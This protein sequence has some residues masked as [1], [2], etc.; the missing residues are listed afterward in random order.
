MDFVVCFGCGG[1]FL[2]FFFRFCFFVERTRPAASMRPPCL[3]YR[4]T[5]TGL[6]TGCHYLISLSVCVC[7]CNIRR[8]TDCESCARP[9]STNP[10]SMEA[11]EYGPTR[12]TWFFA[13]RLEV[14]AVA[15]CYGLSG[16]F[17]VGRIFLVF[18]VT[19]FLNSYTQSSQRRLG[20]GAPTASQSAH[21]ELAPTYPHQVYRL[22]CSHMAS[23]VDQ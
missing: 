20:E 16:V 3:I 15:G 19:T 5:S 12:G 14:V 18:Q 21:R 11:G 13:R 4:S 9:I 23:S 2:C 1:F 8:F 17:W 6:R 7:V 10:A 22:V